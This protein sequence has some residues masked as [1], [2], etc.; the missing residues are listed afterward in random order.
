MCA[1]DDCENASLRNSR[2]RQLFSLV[3]QPLPGVDAIRA[4]RVLLK[5]A[6]RRPGLRCVRL[7]EIGEDALLL[8]AGRQPQPERCT[9]E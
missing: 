5:M 8:E 1:A 7:R 9:L 2:S 6:A 3:L 4:L